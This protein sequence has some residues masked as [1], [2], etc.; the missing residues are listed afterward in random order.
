MGDQCSSAGVPR[1]ANRNPSVHQMYLWTE[2]SINHWNPHKPPARLLTKTTCTAQ[3]VLRF[4]K[5]RIERR[6]TQPRTD[7]QEKGFNLRGF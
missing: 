6:N 2:Q 7:Q 4:S 3:S 1:S 5:G